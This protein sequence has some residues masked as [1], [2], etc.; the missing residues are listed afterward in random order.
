MLCGVWN[1]SNL[2]LAAREST[3]GRGAFSDL[4]EGVIASRM[5]AETAAGSLPGAAAPQPF[6]PLLAT[7]A[8]YASDAQHSR[9]RH[10]QNIAG[11]MLGFCRE[12]KTERAV[13]AVSQSLARMTRSFAFGQ[14]IVAASAVRRDSRLDKSL[15]LVFDDKQEPFDQKFWVKKRAEVGPEK[16]NYFFVN[17]RTGVRTRIKP[18]FIRKKENEG[19]PAYIRIW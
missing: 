1:A 11:G 8:D 15:S 12:L 2:A 16:G 14:F 3:F 9:L 13:V 4:P 6:A 18:S 17:I 7:P 5:K 19:E 10:V